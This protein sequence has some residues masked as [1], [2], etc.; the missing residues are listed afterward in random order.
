M[1]KRGYRLSRNT[2]KTAARMRQKLSGRNSV[3]VQ[4]CILPRIFFKRLQELFAE[5][6]TN[7]C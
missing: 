4:G 1:A 2:S 6:L 3:R 5:E 7:R